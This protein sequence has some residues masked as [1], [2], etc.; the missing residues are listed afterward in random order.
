[1]LFL[2]V[3]SA[4]VVGRQYARKV[5]AGAFSPIILNTVLRLVLLI[6]G[7]VLQM[8]MLDLALIMFRVLFSG[9]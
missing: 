4:I 6:G 1:M 8:E 7:A 2:F 9:F 5:F 3:S